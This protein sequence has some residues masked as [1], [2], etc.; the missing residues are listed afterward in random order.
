MGVT[1]CSRKWITAPWRLYRDIRG[2]WRT[3]PLSRNRHTPMIRT[4]LLSILLLVLLQ[5]SVVS[6]YTYTTHWTDQSGSPVNDL[7]ALTVVCTNS[8]CDNPLGNLVQ[9]K[10]STTD[11]IAVNY[12]VPAPQ[13]GYG[14]F[15]Y[16]QCFLDQEVAFKPTQEGSST[17][18][19]QFTKADSCK[20]EIVSTNFPANGTANQRENLTALVQSPLTELN[21]IPL[22][23]P[24]DADLQQD[25]YSATTHVQLTIRDSQ[26]VAV[27]TQSLDG[28]ILRDTRKPFSFTWMP[29]AAGAYIIEIKTSVTDCKCR[30]TFER[31]STASIVIAPSAQPPTATLL[32]QENATNASQNISGQEPFTASFSCVGTGFSPLNSQLDFGDGQHADSETAS[33]TYLQQGTSLAIC[34][35]TDGAA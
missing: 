20:A 7:R 13:F 27:F 15:F 22:G 6:A 19:A 35:V 32:I 8:Q 17:V 21:H 14:T 28:N 1:R 34:T 16:A 33:H 4:K 10:S 24:Q 11:I 31:I 2:T 29:A 30:S 18:N 25:F 12:P 9:D 3:N 23:E 26:N 5:L